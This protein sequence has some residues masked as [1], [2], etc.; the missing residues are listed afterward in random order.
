MTDWQQTLEVARWEFRRFVKW[1]QQL[2]GLGFILVLGLGGGFAGRLVKKFEQRPVAVAALGVERLGY[3][4]PSAPPVVWDSSQAWTEASARAALDS[5]ALRGVLLV[6]SPTSIRLLMAKR[7]GWAESL[8]RALNGARQVAL[9]TQLAASAPEGAAIL[10]PLK[11]ET[12]FLT[13]GSARSE[14]STRIAAMAILFLG[15]TLVMGGFGT[16]FAGITGEK[17]HRVTEQMIAIVRPQVW[18][19]GKIIGLAA[20]ALVG[21]TVTTLGIFLVFRLLPRLLGRASIALPPIASDYGTLALIVFITMLGVAMWFAF[22]AAV[23]ATIDDPNSSTRT[24]LL[25][26][27]MLPMG[28]AFGAAANADAIFARALGLFPLTATAALP[29]RLV[30]TT[31]PWWETLLSIALIIG[32]VW[33]FRRAAG[34]IFGTAVL[35]YGKE[36][37]FREMWRWMREA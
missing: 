37:S 21:T 23:A 15:F 32:A 9:L 19:D 4:L 22:M 29:M 24:L 30:L 35:M 11:L 26:L 7:A 14:R 18:M 1:K 2:V 27:P 3:A 10:A 13:A 16:L 12:E 25:F 33:L 36:P 8:E 34:K 5:G 28:L 17:Q 20:A 31:V 6:D